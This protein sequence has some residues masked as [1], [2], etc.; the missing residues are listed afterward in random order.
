MDFAQVLVLFLLVG[1]AQG[2]F[3]AVLLLTR[4]ENAAAN[5]ILAGTMA[6]FA[7]FLAESVLYVDGH[8]HDFPHLIGISQP[9]IFIFGPAIYL[10]ARTVGGQPEAPGRRVVLHFLPAAAVVAY[11]MPFYLKTGPEKVAFVEALM[12]DGAPLDV[13]I[14]EWLKLPHGAAYTL[15]TFGVLRRYRR[16]LEESFSTLDRI[17]LGW[18]RDVLLGTMVVWAMA[19]VSS[20]LTLL[21]VKIL[22]NDLSFAPLAL[23]VFVFVIGILGL[24]QPEVFWPPSPANDPAETSGTP[25]A[26]EIPAAPASGTKYRKSGLDPAKAADIEK[27][28]LAMMDEH[29]PQE[30]SDLTLQQLADRLGVS[31]HNL[32]EVINGHLGTSFHDFVNGYRVEEAKRRLRDH[33]LAHQTIL[34]VALESGFR[35]KSTFNKIFKRFTGTTPSQYRRDHPPA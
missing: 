18:L 4:R 26:P 11:F 25:K 22:D 28:L 33:E 20:G 1:V 9:V 21:G 27:A 3:L 30:D 10:Y 2:L 8:F 34:A 14:I 13:Q 5:R 6:A 31:P 17:N 23:V 16:R 29:R 12:R 19:I 7:L 32:S 35:S 15:V 24:R